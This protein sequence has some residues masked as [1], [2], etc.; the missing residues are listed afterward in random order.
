M[1]LSLTLGLQLMSLGG[2]VD[3]HSR[4]GTLLVGHVVNQVWMKVVLATKRFMLVV[5]FRDRET[6]ES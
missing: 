1:K 3:E 5:V 4:T 2:L 6:D